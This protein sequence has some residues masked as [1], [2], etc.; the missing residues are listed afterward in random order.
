[1]RQIADVLRQET[2][3]VPVIAFPR[4]V[5]AHFERD[6]LHGSFAGI[7]IDTTVSSQ[8]AVDHIQRRAAVQ[9]HLSNQTLV[10]G[11]EK[12]QQEVEAMLKALGRGPY[13]FN[14]A[15]GV[16]PQTPPEHVTE[17]LRLVRGPRWKRVPAP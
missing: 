1:M 10:E 9:G 11:G 7:N 15:H 8:W 16:L 6:A 2:A 5:G 17:L 3:G 13:I 14:L 12:M 4:G